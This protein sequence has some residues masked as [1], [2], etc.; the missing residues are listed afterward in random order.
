MQWPHSK[1]C[2]VLSEQFLEKFLKFVSLHTHVLFNLTIRTLPMDRRLVGF[3]VYF[4][5]CA[6]L[7][8]GVISLRNVVYIIFFGKISDQ[9]EAQH[10]N[11]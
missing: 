5:S 8:G 1:S 9:L 3:L 7:N 10:Q 2:S 11:H 6:H 4:H